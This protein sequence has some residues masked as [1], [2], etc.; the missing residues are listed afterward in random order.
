VDTLK[1]LEEEKGKLKI[2]YLYY[3]LK[4]CLAFFKES[5]TGAMSAITMNIALIPV[6]QG[7]QT[8]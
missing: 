6:K 1:D 4:K 3:N 8:T 7:I 2:I 5:Y